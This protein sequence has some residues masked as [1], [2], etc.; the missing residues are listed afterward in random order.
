MV[1]TLRVSGGDSE[2]I[3]T[4]FSAVDYVNA[5]PYATSDG[6]YSVTISGQTVLLESLNAGGY[7]VKITGR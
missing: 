6:D 2:S 4:G 7:T 1:L 3:V 5:S